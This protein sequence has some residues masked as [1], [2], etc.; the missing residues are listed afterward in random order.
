MTAEL[1]VGEFSRI[2]HLSVKTL[3]HYHE[4]GLLEPASINSDTGYRYY[5]TDQIPAAQV[6]RRLRDLDMPVAEVKAVVSTSDAGVRNALISGHLERLENELDKVHAAVNSLR[7]LLDSPLTSI[8]VEYRSIT[9]QRA[10]GIEE[11]VDRDE[12][13]A[14]WYGALGE[15]RAATRAQGLRATGPSG[16]L[17]ASELFQLGHGLATVFIPVE[18][19]VREIGR[20]REI[21]VPQA[22]LAVLTH[23]GPLDNID[24]TYGRLGAYVSEHGISIEGPLREFYVVGVG[25]TSDESKWVTEIGW[26]IFRADQQT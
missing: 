18:G 25:D 8:A 2:S 12:V 24:V 5:S 13:L 9:S 21:V 26:P 4:V 14:W 22:V 3:R 23:H 1:T 10:V 17:F 15:L 20:L 6:I 11:M 19:N 16:K 7:N